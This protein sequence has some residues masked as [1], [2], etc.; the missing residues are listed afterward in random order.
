MHPPY[1]V[2]LRVTRTICG[3]LPMTPMVEATEPLRRAALLS[4]FEQD[5]IAFT[6]EA[7]TEDAAFARRRGLP[8]LAWAGFTHSGD[9]RRHR[10]R[11][12]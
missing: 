9:G 1:R 10:A 11:K 4:T 7:A 5:L 3:Q 2:R 8:A 12:I 6:A